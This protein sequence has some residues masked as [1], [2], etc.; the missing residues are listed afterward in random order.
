MNGQSKTRVIFWGTGN[1]GFHGLRHALE[2]PGIEVVGLHAHSAH[3]QGKDAGELCGLDRQTGIRATNDVD[4][5]I[6]LKP[7]A[8]LYF[9]NG[10]LRPE[11]AAHDIARL[12]EAG[13]NV[14]SIAL[15]VLIN[16][17]TADPALREPIEA[18]CRKGNSTLFV[19]G[20]DPGFSGDLLPLAGLAVSDQVTQI[21]VQEIFDYSTY[22]DPDFTA[23]AFGFGQ[24]PDFTPPMATPGAVIHT[25]GGML[26][27]IANAMGIE[28]EETRDRFE[29][30]FADRD[31]TCK[32]GSIP[33]GTCSGV[34]FAAEGLVDGKPFIV[35]EHVTRLGADQAPD[36]PQPPQG[37][38]GVHRVI[39]R[40]RPDL[41]LDCFA[42]GSDGDHNTGGVQ[43]TANR[44]LNALPHVVAAAPG[45]VTTLDLPHAPSLH[46]R[47]G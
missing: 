43:A 46:A 35:A 6:A 12:L 31:F 44:V 47:T 23:I 24:K 30:C 37:R 45:I 36:W 16:P 1:V 5:L 41:T 39:I 15:I 32:M 22:E 29:R 4:A 20:I 34:R 18:A 13:I 17:H 26:H 7:D 8:A 2:H 27:M 11:E 10:E 25:W 38:S 19:N 3:K 33:K 9:A 21:V 42:I 28:I 14:A 40:G